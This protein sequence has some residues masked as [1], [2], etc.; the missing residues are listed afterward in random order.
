MY[1]VLS[2]TYAKHVQHDFGGLLALCVEAVPFQCIFLLPHSFTLK[3]AS[4]MNTL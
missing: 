3:T 1:A 2:F 4:I